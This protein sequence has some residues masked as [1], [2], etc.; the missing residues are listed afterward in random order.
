MICIRVF[1]L[2]TFKVNHKIILIWWKLL[3]EKRFFTHAH[4]HTQDNKS[5]IMNI[6]EVDQMLLEGDMNNNKHIKLAFF[7]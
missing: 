4:M 6:H 7:C 5:S 2:L 1:K 3:L